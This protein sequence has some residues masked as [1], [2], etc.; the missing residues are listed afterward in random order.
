MTSGR[1]FRG[2][3]LMGKKS[4]NVRVCPHCGEENSRVIDSRVNIKTGILE[5]RRKCNACGFR[6]NAVE[7]DIGTY[8]AFARNERSGE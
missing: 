3:E 5:R 7:I 1:N 2:G 6:W 4:L 8:M